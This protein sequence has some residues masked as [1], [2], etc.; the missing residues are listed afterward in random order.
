MLE[1]I[2]SCPNCSK[3]YRVY[4]MYCGDQTLCGKCRTNLEKQADMSCIHKGVY[5][6]L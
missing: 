1:R 5:L 4:S 3:P 6:C 2:V